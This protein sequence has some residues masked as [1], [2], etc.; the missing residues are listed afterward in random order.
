[1]LLC[2]LAVLSQNEMNSVNIFRSL[3]ELSAVKFYL[4]IAILGLGVAL[5]MRHCSVVEKPVLMH[6]ALS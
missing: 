2:V 1:M 3:P 4:I 6:M 5:S